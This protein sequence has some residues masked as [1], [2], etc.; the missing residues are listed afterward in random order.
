MHKEDVVDIY[1]GILLSPKKEG[2]NPIC[3]TWMDLESVTLSEIVRTRE[4]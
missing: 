4:R 3:T 2:N 1:D